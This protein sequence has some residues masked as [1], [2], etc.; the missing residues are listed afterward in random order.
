MTLTSSDI[1]RI[2]DEI[3]PQA[4]VWRAD[5]SRGQGWGRVID[6]RSRLFTHSLTERT[7]FGAGDGPCAVIGGIYAGADKAFRTDGWQPV[8]QK[9]GGDDCLQ[10]RV[11]GRGE[12]FLVSGCAFDSTW[13]PVAPSKGLEANKSESTYLI[14]HCYGR[15]IRDEFLENDGCL[16]GKL[17][18]VLVDGTWMFLS[19][20]NP[21]ADKGY[22]H[23]GF[24][25]LEQ[26]YVRFSCLPDPRSG[27][28]SGCKTGFGGGAK[29]FKAGGKTGGCNYRQCF[30]LWEARSNNWTEEQSWRS[31]GYKD[32]YV[33]YAPEG[34]PRPFF[35]QL[36][37]GV[38]DLGGHNNAYDV[39]IAVRDRWL[40]QH[41]CRPKDDYFGF[42]CRAGEKH[43]PLPNIGPIR[44][45]WGYSYGPGKV[46]V[47]PPPPPPPPPPDGEIEEVLDQMDAAIRGIR[48][49][50]DILLA[51]LP[52]GNLEQAAKNTGIKN[53]QALIDACAKIAELTDLPIEDFDV[54]VL[55]AK[56]NLLKLMECADALK[57]RATAVAAKLP[58]DPVGARAEVKPELTEQAERLAPLVRAEALGKPTNGDGNGGNGDGNGTTTPDL[59]TA[60]AHVSAALD[61]LVKIADAVETIAERL[62]AASGIIKPDGNNG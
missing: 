17:F 12:N 32:V 53:A 61:Q 33:L 13:D 43:P 8:H 27:S 1:D 14:E 58:D 20:R 15:I 47:P 9:H 38:T 5:P 4:P 51:E 44:D 22:P 39:W 50:T 54:G 57:A 6:N 59:D 34:K 3:C 36:P 11:D 16:K 26:V 19:L 2:V 35:D 48:A 30:F 56:P 28:K 7:A 18:S 49:G 42:T 40:N 62:E 25:Q 37:N 41:D 23:S 60:H 46:D 29:V 55:A 52:S 10:I 21:N 31:G 24:T 45:T